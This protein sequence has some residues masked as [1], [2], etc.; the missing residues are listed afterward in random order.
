MSRVVRHL[1][2]KM[3]EALAS[4]VPV[5]LIVLTLSFTLAPLPSGTFMAFILGTVMLIVGMGLFTLSAVVLRRWL[6]RVR[7]CKQCL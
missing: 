4:V 3:K 7:W 2:L 1:T 5:A 6:Q